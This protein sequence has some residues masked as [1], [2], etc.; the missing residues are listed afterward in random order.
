M[1]SRCLLSF[2]VADTWQDFKSLENMTS[3]T[4]FSICY[5]FEEYLDIKLQLF[6]E[7]RQV[8]EAVFNIVSLISKEHHKLDLGTGAFF[9][10][11]EEIRDNNSALALQMTGKIS[12]GFFLWRHRYTL[13]LFRQ[14]ISGEFLHIYESESVLS[15]K[16]KWKKFTIPYNIIGKGSVKIVINNQY[17]EEVASVEMT[18]E[19][20]LTPGK[21]FNLMSVKGKKGTLKI[22]WSELQLKQNF[23]DYLRA[24]L[25]IRLIVAVDYTSSNLPCHM[26][27]SNHSISN[28]KLNN[29]EESIQHVVH[30]LDVYNKDKVVHLFGFG[31][32]PEGQTKTSHCFKLGEENDYK[33]VLRLYRET[34]PGI[35]M[36]KP[37]ILNEIIAQAQKICEDDKDPNNYYVT[38]I[39]TDGDIHDYPQTTT[40]IVYSCKFPLSFIIVGIG[41][42]DFTNMIK[43]DS[44]GSQLRDRE[45]RIAERDIVQFVEYDL[46]K[47]H[48]GLLAAK[49]L[50]EIPEQICGYMSSRLV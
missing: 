31:G 5:I 19:E 28:K 36:S 46:Y 40:G 12:G 35:T 16:C 50:E 32:I 7:E 25:K 33:G 15:G 17:K 42:A 8:D 34:L 21:M 22:S 38:L 27:N 6:K 20:L 45:G 48:P 1:G 9:L 24:G 37:T 41:K 26:Q 18:I 11:I 10:D 23:V 49:V 2:K 13:N 4:S 30:T 43:L 3:V 14:S 44:D 47:Y 39:L 29:Y